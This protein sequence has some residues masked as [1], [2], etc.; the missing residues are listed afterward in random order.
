MIISKEFGPFNLEVWQS[1]ITKE[2][3]FEWKLGKS[4]TLYRDEN[5]YTY[6]E[7]ALWHGMHYG[8]TLFD[9]VATK[10]DT[11]LIDSRTRDI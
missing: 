5:G 4:P 2:Y 8:R 9:K 1:T 7:I 3:Y 11:A 10:L 6:P